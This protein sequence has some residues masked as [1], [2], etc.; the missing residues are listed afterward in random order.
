MAEDLGLLLAQ[1]RAMKA[2]KTAI[3]NVASAN[4]KMSFLSVSVDSNSD[5]TQ[6]STKEAPVVRPPFVRSPNA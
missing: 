1:G 6:L 4:D 2:S 3:I 5:S